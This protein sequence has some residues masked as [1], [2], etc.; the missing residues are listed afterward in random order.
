M[1]RRSKPHRLLYRQGYTPDELDRLVVEI[2]PGPLVAAL[3]R[4]A[5]G[6]S[7]VLIPAE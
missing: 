6:P 4:W 7:V 1:K 2:G 3:D 5:A